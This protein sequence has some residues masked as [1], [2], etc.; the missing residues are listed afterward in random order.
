LVTSSATTEY[1]GVGTRY[2]ALSVVPGHFSPAQFQGA[3]MTG[4]RICPSGHAVPSTDAYCGVCGKPVIGGARAAHPGTQGQGPTNGFARNLD[5]VLVVLGIASLLL[6][7]VKRFAGISAMSVH[8]PEWGVM[9]GGVNAWRAG[10]PG[11]VVA[12]LLLLG[13]SAFSMMLVLGKVVAPRSILVLR[14][15]SVIGSVASVVLLAFAKFQPPHD[16]MFDEASG[17]MGL[18]EGFGWSGDVTLLLAVVAAVCTGILLT[19]L[20]RSDS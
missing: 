14:L 13:C 18:I 20:G 11:A 4:G 7:F 1:L 9:T 5:L 17:G 10:Q 2:L 19:R 8:H 12:L 3:E 16:G 15:A 6:S